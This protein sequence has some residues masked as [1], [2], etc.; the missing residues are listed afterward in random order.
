MEYNAPFEIPYHLNRFFSGRESVINKIENAFFN[1]FSAS[2]N[3]RVV[4]LYGM[5]GIGKTAIASQYCFFFRNR[6]P[7]VPVFWFDTPDQLGELSEK[8]L[9]ALLEKLSKCFVIL[10]NVKNQ[11]WIGLLAEKSIFF[12]GKLLIT[13]VCPSPG[14]FAFNSKSIEIEPLDAYE[15]LELL[16]KV[17]QDANLGLPTYETIEDANKVSKL[18]CGNPLLLTGAADYIRQN[19]MNFLEYIQIWEKL[20]KGTLMGNMKHIGNSGIQEERGGFKDR[21]QSL[22]LEA[23]ANSGIKQKLFLERLRPLTDK[24]GYVRTDNEYYDSIQQQV[25]KSL[26]NYSLAEI[27]DDCLYFQ[28]AI[29]MAMEVILPTL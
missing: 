14:D 5:T 1:P 4:G 10:D 20:D 23:I 26:L 24:V 15:S 18:M 13:S 11:N 25:A 28:P 22:L 9:I 3:C 6:H 21:V 2:K 29:K 27:K 8:S 19:G 16:I 17:T 12:G 7:N